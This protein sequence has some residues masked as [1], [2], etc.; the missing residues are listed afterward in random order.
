MAKPRKLH[1]NRTN[2]KGLGEGADE[3]Y[4]EGKGK[5]MG[6]YGEWGGGKERAA[7][8]PPTPPLHPQK[9]QQAQGGPN[10]Q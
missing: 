6:R 8:E 10:G 4:E 9:Y 3:A 7:H 2:P 5:G 1:R